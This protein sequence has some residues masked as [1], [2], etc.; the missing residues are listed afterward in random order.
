MVNN[1][2]L[3]R[4]NKP[5]CCRLTTGTYCE[6]HK[7]ERTHRDN[8]PNAYR[9]GYN[10]AWQKASKAYLIKHPYCAEC[11]K[12]DIHTPAT[13][14]DHI[15]PHKGNKDLFWDSSNWQALC[16]HCHDRKTATEDGGFGRAV[17]K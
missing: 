10:S 4:C 17:K 6:V 12:S 11:L 7:S 8:R 15:K 13:V 3:K 2:V 9:R 16:K 14:V 5:G 1:R